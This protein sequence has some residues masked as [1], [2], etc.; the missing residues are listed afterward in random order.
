MFLVTGQIGKKIFQEEP[1][2]ADVLIAAFGG[3]VKEFFDKKSL[4]FQ[5]SPH[6]VQT[7]KDGSKKFPSGYSFTPLIR[8]NLDGNQVDIRYYTSRNGTAATGY[9]YLPE[10]VKVLRSSESDVIQFSKAKELA[11][12]FLLHTYC[13]D[14]PFASSVRKYYVHD[15]VRLSKENAEAQDRLIDILMDL[16]VKRDSDPAGQLAFALGYKAKGKGKARAL[17]VNASSN[18]DQVYMELVRAAK[19]DTMLYLENQDNDNTKIWGMVSV[20]IQKGGI[21][22]SNQGQLTT[23]TW[24]D[25]GAVILKTAGVDPQ[26]ELAGYITGN[27]ETM[28]EYLKANLK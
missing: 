16:K 11:L 12:F 8:A 15:A 22:K 23:Y 20:A 26:T 24:K 4:R 7:M 25:S 10:R 6:L 2:T 13:T 1:V 9:K 27:K 28:L 18:S 14:S 21:V 19:A 17:N 5:H 3:K